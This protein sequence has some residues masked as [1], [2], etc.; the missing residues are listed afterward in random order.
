LVGEVIKTLD[1]VT[2]QVLIETKIVET[3]LS[4]QENLGIDWVTQVSITGAQRPIVW[5]FV[6]RGT[7][8]KFAPDD[9]PVADE[10]QFNFGTINF[11]QLQAILELLRTRTDTNILSNPRIVTLDNQ[12]AR[13][14]VG[15]QYPIP[16]Y[17]YNEEQ[18]RLQVNGFEYKDIGII[19]EV[20]PHVNNKGFITLEIA[21]T[22]TDILDFVQVE[23]TTLPRLS[24]EEAR[25]TDQVTDIR[26]K[27][28]ILGDIP[29]LGLLFQKKEQTVTKTDLLIF[30]TPHIITPDMDDN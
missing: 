27:V 25:T 17:V 16:S 26:K 3:T 4:N 30:L 20:T 22:V 11:T 10:D 24:T 9:F 5:P 2:P 15:S 29:L 1:T 18:A 28:P 8:S 12:L 23:N 13:I 7:D 6:G 21:P 19:F 14:V